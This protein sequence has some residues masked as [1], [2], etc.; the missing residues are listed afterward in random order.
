[1]SETFP[2][3]EYTW[4]QKCLCTTTLANLVFFLHPINIT[5][6]KTFIYTET[7]NCPDNSILETNSFWQTDSCT[8]KMMFLYKY[9]RM[10]VASAL[11]WYAL[12]FTCW[13]QVWSWASLTLVLQM[14]LRL[15]A[16]VHPHMV[17]AQSLSEISKQLVGLRH[18][19]TRY[20]K[21]YLIV[22]NTKLVRKILWTTKVH[23]KRVGWAD[24]NYL[25]YIKFLTRNVYLLHFYQRQQQI[26]L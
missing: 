13:H 15:R 1:M 12:V 17:L 26:S 9:T 4:T 16:P 8:R 20:S 18:I 21:I 14:L 7:L 10:L 25:F 6:N 11:L 22:S 2:L 23:T 24:V 3:D 19:N 5:S